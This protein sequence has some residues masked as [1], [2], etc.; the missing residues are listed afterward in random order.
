MKEPKN[1]DSEEQI[2]SLPNKVGPNPVFWLQHHF[3]DIILQKQDVT[4]VIQSQ[5]QLKKLKCVQKAPTICS[6]KPSDSHGKVM[7]PPISSAHTIQ[8]LILGSERELCEWSSNR[9]EVRTRAATLL[10]RI[11]TFRSLP[12]WTH[13]WSFDF[14]AG[15]SKCWTV[16]SILNENRSLDRQY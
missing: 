3:V 14:S 4:R 2:Q 12:K 7:K 16:I 10:F 15:I 5:P 1:Y 8:G 6:L 13:A 11:V 9:G